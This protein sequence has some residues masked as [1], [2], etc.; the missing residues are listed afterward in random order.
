M[1][2]KIEKKLQELPNK[3][4]VYIM[5]DK[6]GTIIYVGKAKNLKNRVSSYFNKT[7]KTSKVGA[8]VEKID[9]FEYII[10]PSE[11]DAFT[12]ENNLIKKHQPFYNI[13]LKDSKTFPYIKVNLNSTYPTF[14]TTRKV[15]QDGCRY[16]GPYLAGV[17]AKYILDFLNKY[18]HLKTCKGSLAKPL[19]RECI[20]YQMG[21][22]PAPCT[23]KISQ[24]EYRKSVQKAIE[25]LKGNDK[26]VVLDIQNKMMMLAQNENFEKAI[27][28][29]QTFEMLKKLQDQSIANLPKSVSRDAICYVTNGLT[30]AICIVTLQNGRIIAVQSFSIADSGASPSETIEN[31]IT[32]Y[33]QSAII[34]NQIVLSHE[35]SNIETINAFL[36]KNIEF[37][38]NPKGTNLKL[39]KMANENALEHIEK[40]VT[41]DKQKFNNTLGA[42]Q[43][44]KEK[45]GLKKIPMRMECYD[46]SHISGTNKV[47]SMVVFVGGEPKK[48]EY[49]KF[50]IKTVEGNND[51]ASLQ[52]TLKRRLTR[53]QNQ[54][55]E[56][57]KEKPDLLVI[58]GG[59]GQLSSCLEILQE[60]NF[61]DIE[62]IGLAKRIEEVFLPNNPI[63]IKLD[64]S[65]A[66]LKLLQRIRD[67]AHRFGITFHRESRRKTMTVSELDSISGLGPKKKKA[68]WDAFENIEKIKSANIDELKSIKGIDEGLAHKIFNKLH[69]KQ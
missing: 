61:Q 65:T 64:H 5:H 69:N 44:L 56:S 32:T 31:F 38:A 40:N 23:R 59:K 68:L 39:L 18:F 9:W 47:A 29:R 21:L 45:L 24:E 3:S 62:I 7:Q 15:A 12:L 22:C 35:I 48:K 50:K 13:L 57:F 67:E 17:S 49:R 10:T 55:G 8:M 63:S 16:F 46:I 51:F 37:I 60:F 33:Y 6:D 4:G 30:S 28:F 66:G 19:K 34:P 36:G 26:N 43:V 41:R 2:E 58:D 14:L 53:L 42:L 27:E 54:D 11:L 25:F 52:E 1:N 20:S